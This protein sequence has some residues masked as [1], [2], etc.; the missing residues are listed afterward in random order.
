M[1]GSTVVPPLADK[2]FDPDRPYSYTACLY[3]NVSACGIGQY[4]VRCNASNDSYCAACQSGK[5]AHSHY[6]SPGDPVF[7]D[8]CG[9]GCDDG[10]SQAS[11]GTCVPCTND[12]PLGANYSGPGSVLDLPFCPWGC[13]SGMYADGMECKQLPEECPAGKCPFPRLDLSQSNAR[14]DN[15]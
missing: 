14:L 3:C 1:A 11:D 4:R 2:P 13:P 5:P 15:P 8:N 6:T 7:E 10:Y 12:I 9:W